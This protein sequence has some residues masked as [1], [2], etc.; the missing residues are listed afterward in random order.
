MTGANV[1]DVILRDGRT[2]RLRPPSAADAGAVLDLFRR[3]SGRSLHLR[4]HGMP[5]LTP[6]L[7]EPFLEPDGVDRGA[8]L[9]TARDSGSERVVAIASWARLRDPETAEVAFAVEDSMQGK[10][11]GTRL[12]EQLAL[13]AG[14]SGIETFV[15]EVLPDNRE[16]L[17][18]FADAGFDVSRTSAGGE[19]EVRFS[20]AQTE[21]YRA[22]VDERDHIGVVASLKPFFEPSSVAVVGASGREESIGGTVF[23]NIVSGGFSGRAYPVNRSASAVAGLDAFAAVEDL[24]EVPAL[25]VICVPAD[26]LVEVAEAALRRGT[27]ALCVISAGFAEAGSEGTAREEAL[28]SLVRSH[29]ARLLGPNC[30]G[31]AVTGAGLNATFARAAFPPGPIG[32]ASQSGALGLALLEAADARGLGF[33]AFVSIGNKA[34]VSSNDLLEYWEDDPATRLVLLY[35]ESFGNPRKFGRLA[36]RIASRKPL[37]ALKGGSS[38]AGTQAAGSHIAAIAASEVAVEALFRQAGVTRAGTL[39]ELLDVAALFSARAAPRGRRVAVL[40]NAGGLGILCADACAVAGLEL[41]PLSPATVAALRE[42]LTPDAQPGNPVDVLGS[43]TASTYE[44]ALPLLLRDPG[45]DAV[46]ALFAPAASDDAENVAA[47]IRRSVERCPLEKPTL[48]VVLSAGGI[49]ATLREPLD[50]LAAFRYPESAVRALGRAADRA[51]W[52]RR[53]AGSVPLVDADAR[54]ARVLVEAALEEAHDAWLTPARTSELLGAYGIATN[55]G[56]GAAGVATP[57]VE[58]LAGLVQDPVFGPLVAFG[59]GGS[60]GE[61][62]GEAGFRVTPLTDVDAAEL[63]TEGKAGLLAAGF[64]GSPPVDTTA[65]TEL[66]HRLSRLGDDLPEVVEVELDP[67]LGFPDRCLV[68]DARVR[69][70]RVE[71]VALTKTW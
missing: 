45:L 31:I 5:A 58:L 40:T 66:L 28:L 33:S 71:T 54:S 46:L 68:A 1:V 60:L 67:V 53:R 12:L 38:R 44:A 6:A 26:G 63:I 34:D 37:L 70:R 21:A 16:M 10:G 62:V 23:R 25:V 14:S 35:L 22:R 17:S 27:R 42:A 8:L 55:R 9:A 19:V 24:P 7:V 69:V 51:D 36:R 43:A 47:A 32:F 3:L 30:L 50:G 2:L 64:R 15:A 39:E 18:L 11:V 41:G 52:L 29:G 4:F 13:L 59:P 65:L 56:E 57:G 61:L 20:I 49:P 48:A